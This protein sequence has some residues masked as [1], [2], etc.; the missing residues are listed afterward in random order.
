MFRSLHPTVQAALIFAVLCIL[1][2]V[3][4]C[5]AQDVQY[6][7]NYE[8]GEIIVVEAGQPCPYPTVQL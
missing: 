2:L 3:K 1:M 8:T 7:K 5:E 4:P 6:C